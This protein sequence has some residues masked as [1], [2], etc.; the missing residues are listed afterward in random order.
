MPYYVSSTAAEKTT[1]TG[2]FYAIA[3][4]LKVIRVLEYNH[5]ILKKDFLDIFLVKYQINHFLVTVLHL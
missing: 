5:K 3:G 1:I 4:F 2:E